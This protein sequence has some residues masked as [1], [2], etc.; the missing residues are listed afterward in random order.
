V[1]LAVAAGWIEALT[2]VIVGGAFATS[3]I[4]ALTHWAVRAGHLQPFG[5]W[6]RFVRG[7][8]DPMLKP[9]ESRLLRAGGNP[10]Q[11]PWW[12]LGA[13][14][15]G[16]LALLAVV[17]WL[18]GLLLALWYTT[19][20]GPGALLPLVVSL[21]F[22]VLQVALLARVVAS[23]FGISRYGRMMRVAYALTDWLLEPIQRLLPTMGP[24]DFSPLVAYLL[25]G[26]ARSL[27]FSAF[28]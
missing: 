6:P 12:L 23:W 11:A 21:A 24:F 26:L 28:F 19:Q 10:Q 3:A 15:L 25:L 22:N 18:L 7:W 8:S 4:V 17:R 27:V 14:V 16:G 5:G 2:R 9:V 20:A 1:T 13:A